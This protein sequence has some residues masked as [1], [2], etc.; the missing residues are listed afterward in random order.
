MLVDTN[1]SLTHRVPIP[2]SN[3]I[4]MVYNNLEP[5]HNNIT[6]NYNEYRNLYHYVG[7]RGPPYMPRQVDSTIDL[8]TITNCIHK[9]FPLIDF[10]RGVKTLRSPGGSTCLVRLYRPE[11][12]GH[13]P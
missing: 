12:P 3:N 11:S 2:I 1:P 4:I 9:L 8:S 5:I 7:F 10:L 6:I 13:C